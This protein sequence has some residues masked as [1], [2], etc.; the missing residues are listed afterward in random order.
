MSNIISIR[1]FARR[2]DVSEGL[3]RRQKDELSSV[4][5][6]LENGRPAIQWREGLILWRGKQWKIGKENII[7]SYG[8]AKKDGAPSAVQETKKVAATY[9]SSEGA[10]DTSALNH[11]KRVK[12]VYEAK[13][14]ELEYKRMIGEYV[15]KSDVDKRLFEIGRNLKNALQSIPDRIVDNVVSSDTRN[16]AHLIMKKAIN[17][18]L[19]NF[20]NEI[21]RYAN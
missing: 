11:A 16:E 10:T 7:D 2:I 15:K 4:M 20:T 6:V 21:D 1:E 13:L 17:E 5:V 14:K 3:V 12:L 19:L 9:A 18:A 8:D